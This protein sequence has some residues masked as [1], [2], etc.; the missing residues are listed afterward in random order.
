[1]KKNVGSATEQNEIVPTFRHHTVVKNEHI[2]LYIH[3][4]FTAALEGDEWSVQ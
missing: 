2:T 3:A 4:S 1:M